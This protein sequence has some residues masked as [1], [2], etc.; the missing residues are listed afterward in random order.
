MYREGAVEERLAM[1]TL[2]GLLHRE[3]VEGTD[4]EYEA[5][6][7]VSA[8]C[9]FSPFGLQVGATSLVVAA[10]RSIRFSTSQWLAE[11]EPV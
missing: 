2:E 1:G 5:S 4:D 9:S 3:Y 10:Q 7:L 6:D 8:D 11:A